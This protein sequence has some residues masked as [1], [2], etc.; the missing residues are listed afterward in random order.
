MASNL[1]VGF[2]ERQRKCLSKSLPIAPLPT[3]RSCSE[4]P[5]EVLVLDAPLA[6]MPPS[7]VARSDQVLVVSS[8]AKKNACPVQEMT[9]ISQTLGVDHNDKDAPINSH[10]PS[11]EKIAELFNQ[12]PCFIESEPPSTDMN[13]FFPLTNRFFVETASDPHITIAPRLPCGTPEFVFSRI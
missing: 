9:F 13:D 8:S 10:T 2:K 11:W 6:S 3:K 7:D 1:R 5:H 4:D 12:V